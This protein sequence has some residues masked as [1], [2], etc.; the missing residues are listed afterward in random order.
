MCVRVDATV[1]D[2]ALPR[3]GCRCPNGCGC[4]RKKRKRKREESGRDEEDLWSVKVSGEELSGE[5]DRVMGW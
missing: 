5:T 4:W 3:S 1:A 2:L